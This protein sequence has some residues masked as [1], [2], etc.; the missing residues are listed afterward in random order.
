MSENE[1]YFYIGVLFF[2]FILLFSPLFFFGVMGLYYLFNSGKLSKIP[3][4]FG[5]TMDNLLNEDDFY[6]SNLQETY[7]PPFQQ[8]FAEHNAHEFNNIPPPPKPTRERKRNRNAESDVQVIELGLDEDTPLCSICKAKI[9]EKSVFYN[10]DS[11]GKDV[12]RN[13][14]THTHEGIDF[15]SECM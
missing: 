5:L 6:E 3:S 7:N 4:A 12:C 13:C 9:V 8:F 14:V 15:C 2:L 1:A 11:C 10:C